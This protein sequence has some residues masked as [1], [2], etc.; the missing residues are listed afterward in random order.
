MIAIA[1]IKEYMFGIVLLG[2]GIAAV[3]T[4]WVS[5]RKHKKTPELQASS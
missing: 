2:I 4:F 1:F 5:R 3:L